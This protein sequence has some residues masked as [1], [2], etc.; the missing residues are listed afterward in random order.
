MRSCAR[1]GSPVLVGVHVP[2]WLHMRGLALAR[3]EVSKACLHRRKRVGRC[4]A[5]RR[6]LASL[7]PETSAKFARKVGWQTQLVRPA[8]LSLATQGLALAQ[9]ALP[10]IMRRC[11]TSSLRRVARSGLACHELRCGYSFASQCSFRSGVFSFARSCFALRAPVLSYRWTC[12][13]RTRGASRCVAQVLFI[14]SDVAYFILLC[15]RQH[16]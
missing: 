15:P 16:V 14:G 2:R 13:T 8:A 9:L 1:M 5:P 3:L 6:G 4:N 7:A 12:V 11:C 10:D